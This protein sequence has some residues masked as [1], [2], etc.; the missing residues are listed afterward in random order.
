MEESEMDEMLRFFPFSLSL[1]A[2]LAPRALSV[3]RRGSRGSAT[4]QD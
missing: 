1:L 4:A 2:L 3:R